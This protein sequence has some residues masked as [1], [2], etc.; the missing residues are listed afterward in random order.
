MVITEL[1][2]EEIQEIIEDVLAAKLNE[3]KN[4][5]INSQTPIEEEFLTREEASKILK[6][7][8]NSLD[9]YRREKKIPTYRIGGNIRIKKSDIHKFLTNK[10]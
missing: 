2:K 3:L 7:S 8:L 4:D 6:V 9:S 5:I 10:K 1:T